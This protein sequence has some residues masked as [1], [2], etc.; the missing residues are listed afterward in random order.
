M[1]SKQ[2]IQLELLQEINDIC[3]KNDLK[4][5]FVG[6][7]AFNAYVNHT[8][9]NNNAH[10]SIAMTLGDINR[11]CNIIEKQNNPNRYVESMFTNQKYIPLYTSYGNENTT[12]YHMIILNN[13][14]HHGI[15]IR[16]YP[17]IKSVTLDDEKIEIMD[18]KT[19][20]E[21][22]FRKFLNKKIINKK[23]LPIKIG[24]SLLNN[25]YTISGFR[26]KYPNKI[27]NKIYIDNWDD[28]QN[29]S[30]VKIGKKIINSK[31]FKEL[32]KYKVDNIE[33][34]YPKD[35]D[36]YFKQIYGRNI[37]NVNVVLKPKR[38]NAIIDTEI[39]YKKIINETKDLLD[40]IRSTHE[41]LV[42]GRFKVRR[43]K[44]CV[45]NVWKLVKMTNSQIRYINFFNEN[46][47]YL[48]S[49]DLNDKSQFEEME[50]ILNPI[51]EKLQK[52]AN[53]GMTFSI[54]KKTDSLIRKFLLI[55]NNEELI[56]KIDE[57][58]KLK[59]FVE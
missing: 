8:I 58:N 42:W 25:I 55:K 51:I 10:V 13:N 4:Y 27:F 57:I 14:F 50:I 20:K 47:D 44:K 35:T 28:I 11:F 52:Y 21:Y 24:I 2:D 49:L 5:I 7:N 6:K 33:L 32:T 54:D 15:H 9:K 17:I 40:E 46:I 18:S 16:I 31:Y 22:K 26:K 30:N 53:E 41:E 12:D 3:S 45:D 39:S 29:Y 23:F 36:N 56:N 38:K 37:E 43:E 34:N 1:K 19:Y 48:L 59:Y